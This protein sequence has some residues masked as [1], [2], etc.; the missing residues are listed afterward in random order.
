V[1]RLDRTNSV[2]HVYRCFDATGRLIYVGSTANLFGRLDQHRKG[3]WW[4]PQVAK[5]SAKVYRDGPTARTEERRIIRNENPRWNVQGRWAQLRFAGSL[6]DLVDYRFAFT[7]LGNENTGYGQRH[8]AAIDQT[9][10][11]RERRTA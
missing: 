8:L 2:H 11:F 9:I 4:S 6:E 5:V 1:S 10:A 3:S 7:A